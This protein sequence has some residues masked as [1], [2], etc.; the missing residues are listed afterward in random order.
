MSVP[1]RCLTYG[2]T[3]NSSSSMIESSDE[4]DHNMYQSVTVTLCNKSD[5]NG[6]SIMVSDMT[7]AV[8]PHGICRKC[9]GIYMKDQE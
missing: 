2:E 3:T 1:A 4:F 5:V 8:R 9:W 6:R 7:S